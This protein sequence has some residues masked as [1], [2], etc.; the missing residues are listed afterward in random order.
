MIAE[1][2]VR[3]WQWA[4]RGQI[5][6]E[7]LGGLSVERRERFWRRAIAQ[8]GEGRLW[9]AE[10]EGTVV[11]FVG[12]AP[13]TDA[14]VTPEVA[15]ITAI[16]LEPAVIGSGVGRALIDHGIEDLRSRGF[17]SAV[18]W[19]LASNERTRRYLE[20]RGWH[21][22]GATRTEE[23]PGVELGEVRYARSLR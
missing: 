8:P 14:D 12:T 17:R 16:Y 15:D 18:W 23:A 4:Y 11:G 21:A 6:D 2:H 9:V 1:I 20:A 10:R 7:F 22:D 19:V 13:A 3:G 5:S